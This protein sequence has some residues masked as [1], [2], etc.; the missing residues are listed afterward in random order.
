[1]NKEQFLNRIRAGANQLPLQS[2]ENY[3]KDY[4]GP[5]DENLADEYARY[6]SNDPKELAKNANQ[7]NPHKKEMIEN[8]MFR[9]NNP[10]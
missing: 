5:F 1:M 9:I 3:F 2:L 10:L 4:N 6:F 8:A 7:E